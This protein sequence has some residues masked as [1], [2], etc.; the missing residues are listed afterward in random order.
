MFTRNP[1][2]RLWRVGSLVGVLA[3]VLAT[4]PAICFAESLAEQKIR[5]AMNDPTSLEFIELPLKDAVDY[6]KDLHGIE[7]QFDTT[8]MDSLGVSSDTPVTRN[9]KGVSLRSALSLMLKDLHLAI[10]I[11][12]DVLQITSPEVA[13]AYL[14]LK[15]HSVVDLVADMERA[16]LIAAVELALDPSSELAEASRLALKARAATL[17]PSD[18]KG[19]APPE[20]PEPSKT[21]R[22]ASRVVLYR[23][24]LIVRGN[25]TEH[26][27]IEELLSQI[28][29]QLKQAEPAVRTP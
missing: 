12:D 18:G 5:R 8:A 11:K 19:D 16:A 27:R 21:I 20:R 7:I 13:D 26:D 28:R 10:L 17:G 24:V 6:L 22:Q 1:V 4:L 9:L 3:V 15:T 14:T 29:K 23:E 2:I 25:P